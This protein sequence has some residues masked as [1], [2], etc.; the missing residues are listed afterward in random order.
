M[1]LLQNHFWPLLQT[2]S[3]QQKEAQLSCEDCVLAGQPSSHLTRSCRLPSR[4]DQIPFLEKYREKH[5]ASQSEH[6]VRGSSD[7][8]VLFEYQQFQQ[9]THPARE[10]PSRAQQGRQRA[11]A[12]FVHLQRNLCL[13]TT[14]TGN[15]PVLPEDDQ[16][17]REASSPSF[18]LLP[19][20]A[21][22][23]SS[24]ALPNSFPSLL[25]M[26]V[27]GVLLSTDLAIKLARSSSG[28][29]CHY[30]SEQ[31]KKGLKIPSTKNIK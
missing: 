7:R 29:S 9:S 24:A 18:R 6:K 10:P 20:T 3:S 17:Q 13:P 2:V 8:Q 26:Q 19:N 16:P 28:G 4:S 15:K 25:S 12:T 5:K 22:T 11:P 1:G 14:S 21:L 23:A 30:F 27:S 31:I